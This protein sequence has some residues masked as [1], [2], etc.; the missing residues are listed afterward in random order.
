MG[1]A[2]LKVMLQFRRKEC[3]PL[4]LGF[5]SLLL[6]EGTVEFKMIWYLYHLDDSLLVHVFC[7]SPVLRFTPLN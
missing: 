2:N 1:E 5:L 3:F 4:H 7:F 6:G